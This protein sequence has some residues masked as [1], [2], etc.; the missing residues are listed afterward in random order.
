[1]PRK[2]TSRV[3]GRKRG[4]ETRFYA[5]LRDLGGGR[6]ALIPPGDT[7]ATTDPDIA[8]D[9]ATRRVR[10]LEEG[11]RRNALLGVR[12]QVGLK[13]FA[14]HH[15]K[16]KAR[17]GKTVSRWMEQH[18]AKLRAACEFFGDERPLLSIQVS[19]VQGWANH[20]RR[21]PNGRGGTLSEGSVRHYLNVLS[22]LYRRSAA[23][24]YVPPGF[25]PVAAMLD[26]PVG[27]REE[28]RWLEVHEGALLLE[29]ARL[30]RPETELRVSS[31]GGRI[32]AHAF[33][34]TYPLLAT[35]LLTGG[36]QS[37]VLGLEVEDVSF[38]RKTV[39]FRPNK[40]RRLKT[41]TSHRTVPL[42][43]QLEDVLRSYLVARERE[44]GIGEL[45]FP[46]SRKGKEGMV[47]DIRK[48]LDIIGGRAGW[49]PGE[50][51]SKMFRHTY[52]AARLQT[53][54]QGVPV[55]PFTVGREMGHGGTRL[56][57]RIYGHLGTFR[58]RSEVVEFRAENHRVELGD[59]LKALSG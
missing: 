5:D 11:R 32:S 25:N 39:T 9:L 10:E 34:W 56:V 22:N 3:Y 26:K 48:A 18:E 29:S 58:H 42:W 16:E 23:E 46:S 21:S 6:E 14:A 13:A 55:S 40:W 59:R 12:G 47:R 41:S 20:L 31:A 1:M 27:R 2:R 43:P 33:P 54:D 52:C 35:F 4:G 50:I 8:Q 51:R 53:L 17:V 57:E 24:R 28:A 30:Y 38:Q 7:S 45:L 44:G 19:D 36:R 49:K 15:L 37:E